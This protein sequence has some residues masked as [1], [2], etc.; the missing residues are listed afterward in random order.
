MIFGTIGGWLV[1]GD[2]YSEGSKVTTKNDND[3][4][5]STLGIWVKWEKKVKVTTKNDIDCSFSTLGIL[6]KVGK[7][8]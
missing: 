5:F 8:R 1:K 2:K 7:N 3:C 6:S 4:S